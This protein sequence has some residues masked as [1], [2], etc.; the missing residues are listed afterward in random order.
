MSFVIWILLG[1]L[2]GRGASSLM[3]IRER[4]AIIRN[5]VIGI[6][7]VMLAGWLLGRLVGTSVFVEGEFSL[8][9]LLVALL[10]ATIP[11]A[12]MQLLRIRYFPAKSHRQNGTS[13][14]NHA[15]RA[16]SVRSFLVQRGINSTQVAASGKG[17][18]RSVAH[19][20]SEGGRQQNRRVEVIIANPS[21]AV[22]RKTRQE[23]FS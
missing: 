20:E 14:M 7:G 23:R 2:L 19:N 13:E 16:D 1:G 4:Q 21:L 10:G 12:A 17:E 3:G 5:V 15:P 9:S 11:L 8:S 6:A 22:R 18:Q